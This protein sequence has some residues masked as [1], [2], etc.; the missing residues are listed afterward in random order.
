VNSIPKN[1]AKKPGRALLFPFS[2]T[3]FVVAADQAIKTFIAAHWPQGPIFD[4]FDNDFIWIYHVRNKAIAFSLGDGLPDMAKKV[5][6]V[7][8]PIAALFLILRYYFK[9]S[10][11]TPLQRWAIAGV[12]GGGAGNLLD[13]IFRPDGVVDFVSIKL[14]GFLG[15]ERWPTFNVADAAVVVCVFLFIIGMFIGSEAEPQGQGKGKAHK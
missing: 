6:F 7:I 4:V 5:L 12:I 3:L 1:D 13:R 14:Y 11:F 8:L 9:T 15:I 2:L 10:E